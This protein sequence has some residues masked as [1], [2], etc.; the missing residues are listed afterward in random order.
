MQ[1]RKFFQNNKRKEMKMETG[2]IKWYNPGKGYGFIVTDKGE[3]IFFHISEVKDN[4]RIDAGRGVSFTIES[5][6]KGEV[7]KV[8]ELTGFDLP[9][10]KNMWKE[11]ECSIKI[12]RNPS[13]YIGYKI[14]DDE[15]GSIVLGA[16]FESSLP[17]IEC[18][19]YA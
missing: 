17:D 18:Y 19:Y 14:V 2:T 12:G 10:L 1:I 3:D 5:N 7:A 16:N 4:E 6:K 8:V 15:D 13:G 11:K 9:T